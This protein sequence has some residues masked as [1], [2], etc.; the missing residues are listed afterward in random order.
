MG[1][2][3]FSTRTQSPEYQER[4]YHQLMDPMPYRKSGCRDPRVRLSDLSG[5][6]QLSASEK[7]ASAFHGWERLSESGQTRDRCE[8]THAVLYV[9]TL[10][11]VLSRFYACVPSRT[12]I[13][14]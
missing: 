6:S 11:Q 4:I 7:D 9:V 14:S 10:R 8:V 13:I 5:V 3:G 1:F 2:S 12:V